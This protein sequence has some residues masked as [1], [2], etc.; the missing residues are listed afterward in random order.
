MSSSPRPRPLRLND[1]R[2]VVATR[3]P[4]GHPQ[5]LRCHPLRQ[6]GERFEPFPTLYW[7]VCP[8]LTYAL[9][10]LEHEGWIMRLGERLQSDADFRAEVEQDHDAYAAARWALLEAHEIAEIRRRGLEQDL[11]GRGIGG[12]RDRAAVK[13]LHLHY[14]HHLACGSAI[15]RALDEVVGEA[16]ELHPCLAPQASG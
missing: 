15:G 3:C 4:A 13:C 5:V 2:H 6:G 7:L 8:A 10:K 16:A 11:R 14:A 12:I 9:S 1:V